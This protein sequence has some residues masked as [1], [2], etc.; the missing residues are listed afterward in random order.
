MDR[1]Y[2]FPNS[3]ILI[4]KLD[5]TD[6]KKLHDVER[7]LTSLRILE[8]IEKPVKG[9][10]DFEHLKKI[11]EYIFQD[12]Y[13]WAGKVR[14]VDIEKGN[15]FCKVQ[16]IQSQADALFGKLKQENYLCGI[17]KDKITERVAFYFAEINALHP[18]RE[19]NG[20]T[21][22]E[23]IRESAINAGYKICFCNISEEEMIA[24]SK[25]SFMCNYK[26]LEDIF[27]KC[28]IVD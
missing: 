5:I 9:R 18:F 16:F 13:E 23:F 12:I 4:N 26:K 10:F 17:E 27:C 15:M 19:G 20:R 11:H 8:L 22:R 1:V 2:C 6:A 7:K 21:Q 3:N 14:M 28:M 25:D 24:A